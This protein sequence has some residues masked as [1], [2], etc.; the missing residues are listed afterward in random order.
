[1]YALELGKRAEAWCMRAREG[2]IIKVEDEEEWMFVDLG[3]LVYCVTDVWYVYADVIVMSGYC[4]LFLLHL[5]GVK[6]S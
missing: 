4:L 2:K 1:M 6:D 3:S 5:E